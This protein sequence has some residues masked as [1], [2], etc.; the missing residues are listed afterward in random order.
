MILAKM[1]QNAYLQCANVTQHNDKDIMY[2]MHY[3]AYQH[4]ANAFEYDD[5]HQNEQNDNTQ[6]IDLCIIIK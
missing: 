4:S 5:I 2:G 6:H 3:A 1:S